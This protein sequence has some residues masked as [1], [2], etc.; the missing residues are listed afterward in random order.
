[1]KIEIIEWE[2]IKTNVNNKPILRKS[3]RFLFFGKELNVL[4]TNF[5][6]CLNYLQKKKQKDLEKELN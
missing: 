6:L 3:D 4:I 5:I 2:K 1:M